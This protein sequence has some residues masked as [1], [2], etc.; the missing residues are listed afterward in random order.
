MV[1]DVDDMVT[2]NSQPSKEWIRSRKCY[3]SLHRT[4]TN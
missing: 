3:V 2:Y 4:L 1:E